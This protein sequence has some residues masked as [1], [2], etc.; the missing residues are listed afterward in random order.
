M[1]IFTRLWVFLAL[2][3]LFL[4]PVA[5]AQQENKPSVKVMVNEQIFA[6]N[7]V[8]YDYYGN[9]KDILNIWISASQADTTLMEVLLENGFKV[10]AGAPDN[11]TRGNVARDDIMKA[12]EGDDFTSTNLGNY[13]KADVLIVGK[14]VARGVSGLKGS[15]QKSARANVNV[16]AIKIDSGEIIAVESGSATSAAIDEVS[17]GVEAVKAATRSIALNLVKK[18]SEAK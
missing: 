12:T 13:L 3:S 2:Y 11:T 6:D 1:K 15:Q 14:A 7:S 10:L 18:I 5:A 16:R 17:A 4:A 8:L 9:Q